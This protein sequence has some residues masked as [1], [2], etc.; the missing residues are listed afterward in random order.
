VHLVGGVEHGTISDTY[1]TA[2]SGS[3]GAQIESATG[4]FS[5]HPIN[6]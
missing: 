5:G 2:V 1:T 3:S 6:A 4:K